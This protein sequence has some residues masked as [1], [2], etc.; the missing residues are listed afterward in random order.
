MDSADDAG[1]EGLNS[2]DGAAATVAGVSVFWIG[3]DGLGKENGD[4]AVNG[5]APEDNTD[6]GFPAVCTSE[7]E[8]LGLNSVD[9]AG[10]V[11][12][13]TSVF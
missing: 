6:T 5:P 10:V 2:V 13:G 9:C 3:S 12:A 1:G 11:T 7:G 8:V 4:G